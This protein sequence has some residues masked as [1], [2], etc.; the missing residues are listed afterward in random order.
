VRDQNAE[1]V[2]DYLAWCRDVRRLAPS[3]LY[4]YSSC[5]ALLLDFLRTTDLAAVTVPQLEAFLTRKRQGRAHGAAGA[6]ATQVRDK[7]IIGSLYSYL[8]G[9]G[10][11]PTNPTLLLVSP[12]VANIN[13]RPVPDALWREVWES[14]LEPVER[15]LLGLGM[16]CGFRRV[17]MVTIAPHMV[18]EH[19][20]VGFKRKG[21]GDDVFPLADVMDV[22]A[23]R[24][25]HLGSERF[26]EPLY[27]LKEKR[28]GK[29]FLIPRLTLFEAPQRR[30]H[31]FGEQADPNSL[32]R[33]LHRMFRRLGL[34]T[35]SF[36]PH[37]L[38]HGA[39]T[40]WL[41]AGV[42]LHL[43]SRLA[44]HSDVSTTLRY[45][46]AGGTELREWSKSYST[47]EVNR[48]G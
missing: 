30:Y 8:H 47:R 31:E 24:M 13:P 38:R 18:T 40:N 35:D 2:R 42:P 11:V 15:V 17:E 12:R 7:A 44:N 32:N 48:F 5:L 19:A 29:T 9:R 28:V 41:R 3:S 14:E 1:L 46:K 22:W 36:T 33:A 16:F 25:P 34:P 39:I 43:V 21:G 23:E 4:A 45:T 26:L 6:P 27:A 37:A 20:F 10:L